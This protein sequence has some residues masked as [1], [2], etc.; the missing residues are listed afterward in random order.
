MALHFVV[1]LS[2]L[3]FMKN[4]FTS[5]QNMCI[6]MDRQTDSDVNGHP[7][8]VCLWLKGGNRKSDHYLLTVIT[9]HLDFWYNK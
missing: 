6:Q 2:I 1:A 7:A 8:A 5:S 3:S 9:K 4:R